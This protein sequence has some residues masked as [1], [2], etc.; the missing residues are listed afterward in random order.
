MRLPRR[1]GRGFSFHRQE[2]TRV[3]YVSVL[4]RWITRPPS[5]VIKGGRPGVLRG[6]PTHEDKAPRLTAAGSSSLFERLQPLA[7]DGPNPDA[8][9]ETSANKATPSQ[10]ARRRRCHA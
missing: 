9:Y 5:T 8:R 6:S 3:R 2:Q 7:T 4:T 10:P 1:D